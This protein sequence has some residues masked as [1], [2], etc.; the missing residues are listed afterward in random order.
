M[1][2]IK[3]AL[4]SFCTLLIIIGFFLKILPR[5]SLDKNMKL[6]ISLVLLL[7]LVSPFF[8]S[9]NAKD[10]NVS[11]DLSS[12]YTVSQDENGLYKAAVEEF[13]SRVQEE[14]KK[15]GYDFESVTVNYTKT[16]D[17]IAINKIIITTK[18]SKNKEKMKN[19]IYDKF[20]APVTILEDGV[21]NEG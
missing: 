2:T 10:L 21:Q 7:V 19:H 15:A 5:S 6:V 11:S 1:S 12:S 17:T 13:K 3:T 20:L 8:K 9:F 16:G 18:E 4:I 14:L